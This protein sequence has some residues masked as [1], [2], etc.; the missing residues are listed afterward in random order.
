M[1]PALVADSGVWQ[2]QRS[3][4]PESSHLADLRLLQCVARREHAALAEFYTRHSRLV[5]SIVLRILRSRSDSEEVLQDVFVQVWKKAD[6]YDE[7]LGCPAAWL[8]RIARNRAIDRIRSKRA[9]G[10]AIPSGNPQDHPEA[11]QVADRETP[12][13]LA[14]EAATASSIRGVLA[15]LP[16][17]QREL[18]EAAF[19]DGFTHQELSERFGLPLGTVKTRIRSGL[20]AM[21]ERL[22]HYV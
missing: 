4:L 15:E 1:S 14:Q 12:E 16:T 7:R 19:F 5:F 22:E 6:T 21:R 2:D 10:E 9:R 20:L 18:I 8:T 11:P 3:V 13:L 17:G